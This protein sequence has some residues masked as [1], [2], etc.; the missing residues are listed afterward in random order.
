MSRA[1]SESALPSDPFRS[2]AG[3]QASP[4]PLRLPATAAEGALA[5]LRIGRMR[6]VNGH[7]VLL[8]GAVEVVAH[9]RGPVPEGLAVPLTDPRSARVRPRSS[10]CLVGLSS[11]LWVEFVRTV[12]ISEVGADEN[13]TPVNDRELMCTPKA[14]ENSPSKDHDRRLHALSV[15]PAA[16]GE[17]SLWRCRPREVMFN[18]A[19]CAGALAESYSV[20]R[21]GSGCGGQVVVTCNRGA[22]PP[23]PPKGPPVRWE[24]FARSPPHSEVLFTSRDARRQRSAVCTTSLR[25]P[26]STSG[27][28]R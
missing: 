13:V 2:G 26:C 4:R 12:V 14:Q 18:A 28:A 9:L 11:K 19:Q 15:A 24:P 1:R 6:N 21:V 8:E 22:R 27:P 5:Q 25:Q 10:R 7:A 23:C 20:A 17:R 3:A 16:T